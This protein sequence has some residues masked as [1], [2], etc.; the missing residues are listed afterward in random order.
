MRMSLTPVIACVLGACA[1]AASAPARHAEV[2][3]VPTPFANPKLTESSGVVPSTRSPGILWTHNDSGNDPLLFAT[4]T[5]GH[6]LG[7]I[8]VT[9]AENVDWEDL[10]IGPCST[11]ICLYIGDTGDNREVRSSVAVYRVPEPDVAAA[12]TAL[13]EKLELHYPDGP[14]DAEA[15][16]VDA[17]GDLYLVTKGR[18]HGVLLFRVKHD[19]WGNGAVMAEP[20]GSLPLDPRGTLVDMVTGADI[21]ARNDLMVLRTYRNIYL[22][23]L[24]PDGIIGSPDPVGVCNIAGLESQGE[25]IAWLDES[26]FVLTSEEGN[27]GPGTVTIL[28]CP[29]S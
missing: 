25:G 10:A 5:L 15:M 22:F 16:Y 17:R 29:R 23:R 27:L 9:G 2:L 18:S 14:H 13:A 3:R 1:A 20:V 12:R 6:D 28:R 21:N 19:A 11:T 7:T 26:R 8:T 24:L 4:D